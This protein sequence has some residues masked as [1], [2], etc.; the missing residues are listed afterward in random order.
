VFDDHAKTELVT[1]YN[2]FEQTYMPFDRGYALGRTP[3]TRIADVDN[4]PPTFLDGFLYVLERRLGGLSQPPPPF[5]LVQQT[6]DFRLWRRPAVGPLPPRRPAELPGRQG[7]V[8]V[9]PGGNLGLADTSWQHVRVGVRPL[10]GWYLPMG[11]FATDGTVWVPWDG[12]GGIHW[13][14]NGPGQGPATYDLDVGIG[15]RYRVSVMGSMTPSFRVVIDGQTLRPPVPTGMEGRDGGQYLGTVE[16]EPGRHRVEV[17]SPDGI[18]KLRNI[19]FVQGVS[20]ELETPPPASAVCINGKRYEAAWDR[21]VETDADDGSV[22]IENCGDV[23]LF[24]DW[25]EALPS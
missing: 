1:L 17:W 25:V 19:S 10:D 3:K 6:D 18:S 14:S 8:A 2:V 16:L 21:P 5:E 22:A 12:S 13:V 7:G 4:F 11:E 24:V 20:L 9:E 23:P 15:G